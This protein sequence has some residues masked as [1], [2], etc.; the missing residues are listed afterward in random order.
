[1]ELLAQL[2][3]KRLHPKLTAQQVT[4][5]VARVREAAQPAAPE[6]PKQPT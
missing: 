3:G 1:M 2:L 6:P 5:Y 4:D